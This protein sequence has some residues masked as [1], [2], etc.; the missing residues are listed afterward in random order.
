MTAIRET[1]QQLEIFTD[2]KDIKLKIHNLLSCFADNYQ[3]SP[4]YLSGSWDG[5]KSF[6]KTR[7]VKGGGIFFTV[8]KGFKEKLLKN[9]EFNVKDIKEYQKPEYTEFIKKIMKELPF[10]PYK[11]QLKGFI[12]MVRNDRSFISACTGS[13]K[14]LI[15]YLVLRFYWE[16]G[17]KSVLLVPTISLTE[18]MLS[19]FKDYKAPEKF[20]TDI[21]LIGGDNIDKELSH[22]IIIGTYQSLVKV[23]NQMKDYDIILN[24]ECHLA[25]AESLQK[26]LKEPFKIKLGMTGSVPIIHENFMSLEQIFGTPEYIIRAREL[27]DM[28]LLTDS[29]IVCMFLKYPKNA[30]KIGMRSNFKYHDEIKFI[31]ENEIRHKFVSKFAKKLQN[32]QGISVF[33]YSHTEHG[34][35]TFKNI[36]GEYPKHNDI[37]RMKELGVFF[38]NGK[39][40]GKIREEI[41]KYTNEIHNGIIIANYKVFSTG[42]NLPNISNI[43]FLSPV[44]SF[45]TILQSLGRV[46][47]LKQGKHKAMIYDLIDV[48]PYSTENYTLKHFWHR[49]TYYTNEKHKI[50]EREIDL[51]LD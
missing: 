47:R 40:K 33:L 11:H 46:F 21:K 2:N 23:T 26:I 22:P 6:Y 7:L 9:I 51:R 13:G 45:V 31:K 14:S 34:E 48:F 36:T 37:D 35:E 49:D 17:K 1:D 19:D 25:S 41:R 43:I 12:A 29:Y 3:N 38:V 24:D 10:K 27:M 30:N 16:M 15:A 42:I 28:G 32:T 50:I 18:Q 5:K 4:K 44:K 39:T 8:E 20:I